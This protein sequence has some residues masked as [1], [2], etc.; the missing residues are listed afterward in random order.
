M[1]VIPGA[2]S[3]NNMKQ[4]Q[5]ASTVTKKRVTHEVP[6]QGKDFFI[7]GEDRLQ[8]LE[9]MEY[10]IGG[11]ADV[12]KVAPKTPA[13]GSVPLETVKPVKKKRIPSEKQLAH[14]ANMRAKKKAKKATQPK[15]PPTT[16]KATKT[17][18]QK[19]TKR[20]RKKQD[21]KEYFNELYGEKEKVRVATKD[22]RRVEKQAIYQKLIASGQLNIGRQAAPAP[23]PAPVPV[24]PYGKKRVRWNDGMLE[25]Y[26][27]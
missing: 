6:K 13:T 18:E 5:K 7:K 21:M 8:E 14:L 9:S 22:K 27:E 23:A 25:T 16:M 11:F 19:A 20:A 15:A 24:Q 1:S 10:E 3:F 12:P 4:E 26:F 2:I 17:D